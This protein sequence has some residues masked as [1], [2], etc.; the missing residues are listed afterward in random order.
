M[1]QMQYLNLYIILLH[2]VDCLTVFNFYHNIKFYNLCPIIVGTFTYRYMYKM[3]QPLWNR[4]NTLFYT[5]F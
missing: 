3:Y 2:C 5:L 4:D 1:G